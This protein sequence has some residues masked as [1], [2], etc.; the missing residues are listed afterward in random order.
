MA[1]KHLTIIE[2]VKNKF[3][4]DVSLSGYEFDC[5]PDEVIA[6]MEA[7]KE[8][9]PD[10]KLILS[11]EQE[12]YDDHYSLFVKRE[13]LETDAERDAR[14]KKETEIRNRIENAERA[15]YERLKAKFEK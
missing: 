6:K 2:K 13:R 7:L 10:D 3:G 11:W 1:R 8:E 15:T 4:G 5:T 12:P 14:V 9:Y